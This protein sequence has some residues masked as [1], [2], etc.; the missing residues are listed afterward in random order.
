MTGDVSLV[1]RRS[2]PWVVNPLSMIR[3]VLGGGGAP[4]RP[5]LLYTPDASGAPGPLI[6]RADQACPAP[7]FSFASVGGPL[8]RGEPTL[9]EPGRRWWAGRPRYRPDRFSKTCQVC[10]AREGTEESGRPP[11]PPPETRCCCYDRCSSCGCGRAPRRCRHCCST[12]RPAAR[13]RA[14]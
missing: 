13:L 8:V 9:P 10:T 5:K 2:A 7:F 12:S 4:A 14:A 1:R 6:V 3:G 11:P